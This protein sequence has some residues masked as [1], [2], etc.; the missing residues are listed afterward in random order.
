[1]TP[2]E[3]LSTSVLRKPKPAEK[4][5]TCPGT[6]TANGSGAVALN[7]SMGGCAVSLI[8]SVGRHPDLPYVQQRSIEQPLACQPVRDPEIAVLMRVTSQLSGCVETQEPPW[9]L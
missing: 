7:V 9:S 8:L 4:R 5:D 2:F 3:S 6:F 1:M